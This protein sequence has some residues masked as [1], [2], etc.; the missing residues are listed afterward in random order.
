MTERKENDS[1][2]VTDL[3]DCVFNLKVEE[4]DIEKMY[5]L[6]RWAE[7]DDK[8][9]PLLVTFQNTDLKDHVEANLRNLKHTVDN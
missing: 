5:R 6:G 8:V 7:N 2:Y 9:R 3:L 1:T 4:H